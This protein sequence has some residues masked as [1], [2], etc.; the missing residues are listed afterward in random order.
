MKITVRRRDALS[1]A[2]DLLVDE[3]AAA[4]GAGTLAGG[5]GSRIPDDADAWAVFAHDGRSVRLG[6][7]S[8]PMSV[9]LSGADRPFVLPPLALRGGVKER[10]LL[11]PDALDE[12]SSRMSA[13]ILVE[14]RRRHAATA[15]AA[16]G[17][18]GHPVPPFDCDEAFFDLCGED[19]GRLLATATCFLEPISDGAPSRC[20]VAAA[21]AGVRVISHHRGLRGT[22]FIAVD[23]WSADAF[24]DA[25]TASSR[26]EAT[27]EGWASFIEA[28]KQSLTGK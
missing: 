3:M 7:G 21:A 24:A 16:V 9:S 6:E 28:V 26:G 17:T 13:K 1:L 12:R 27:E 8:G 15:I 14:L 4:L 10:L 20:A 5:S 18:N 25:I 2:E 19:F 11:A 22:N 23:E